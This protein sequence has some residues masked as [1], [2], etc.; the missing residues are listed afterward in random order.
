[1]THKCIKDQVDAKGVEQLAKF[2]QIQ[3][4]GQK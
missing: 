4:V 3:G 2:I 1:M